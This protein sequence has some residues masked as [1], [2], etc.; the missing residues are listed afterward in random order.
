VGE[1]A[2]DILVAG[3][4]GAK[5]R[6]LAHQGRHG[7]EGRHAQFVAHHLDGGAQ[8]QGTVVRI[9]R[10]GHQPVAA[11]HFLIG[12]AG[13]FPA[14]DQ[15]HIP[16]PHM[17][18]YVLHPLAGR[19]RV[20]AP[21]PASGREGRGKDGARQG[22][23]QGG[24]DMGLGQHVPGPGGP[25]LRLWIR[26]MLGIDQIKPGQPH[27][28]H[29]PGGG[30]DIARVAGLTKNNTDALKRGSRGHSK[31][32]FFQIVLGGLPGSFPPTSRPESSFKTPC[33]QP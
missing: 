17:G 28:F 9:H 12:Q 26:E 30:A 31:I 5:G 2:L 29:G 24:A 11:G 3:G 1:E 27:G 7:V 10:Y 20:R 6:G 22:F 19:F 25:S 14:E 18:K 16:L 23:I 4:R 21:I 13:G 32:P 8:V 15:G 33:I